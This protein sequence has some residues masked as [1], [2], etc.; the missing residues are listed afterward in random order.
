[1]EEIISNPPREGGKFLTTYMDLEFIKGL[2]SIAPD[3]FMNSSA[4]SWGRTWLDI[5]E[6]TQ[7]RSRLIIDAKEERV[8]S[9][10]EAERIIKGTWRDHIYFRPGII[11]KY[12]STDKLRILNPFSIFMV[13]DNRFSTHDMRKET[14]LF[15]VTPSDLKQDWNRLFKKHDI[16][17]DPSGDNEFK[18]LD[19]AK[20]ANPLNSVIISDKYAYNQFQDQDSRR[21]PFSENI[22]SL[23]GALIPEGP[24]DDKFHVT[25]VTNLIKLLDEYKVQPN[26]VYGK[27]KS[28]VKRIS[29]KNEYS[30]TVIS[31]KYS[32]SHKDRFI[33]TN[34]GRLTCNDSFSFFEDDDLKKDTLIR[35]SPNSDKEN[36][37]T[38]RR[39]RRLSRLQENPPQR[40]WLDGN[41]LPVGYGDFK[42]RLLD[43]VEQ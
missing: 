26:Y 5:V 12:T 9:I 8:N 16:D 13:G 33:F 11:K 25:L 7:K 34:Y 3:D 15:F 20:Y 1:M 27:I 24:L 21:E 10:E 38:L 37:A 22:G 28:F 41:A 23:L 43:I 42:N 6:F 18:W 14:G 4:G 35:Y 31:Y 32:G 17:V 40:P 30:V 19:L 36:N 2:L 29:P 39:L